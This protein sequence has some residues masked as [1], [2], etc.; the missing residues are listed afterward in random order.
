MVWLPQLYFFKPM[1]A[2]AG[3]VITFF[4][5]YILSW[6]SGLATTRI[7]LIGVALNYTITAIS[8]VIASM[9]SSISSQASGQLTFMTWSDVS[10]LAIYLIPILVISLFL[11]KACDMMGLEDKTLISLG[12]NVN[13]Y[14]F[15][16]SLIAVLLCSIS[17]S[18][19]GVISFVGLIVPHIA[20]LCIGHEHKYLLPFTLVLGSILVL[21][22]DTLGRVIIA[23]YELS[24]GIMMAVIGGPLFILLLKRG[25]QHD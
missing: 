18:V 25:I 17:V 14:R 4:I 12:V 22:A 15:F 5:I 21:L 13:H 24:S 2:F 7:L 16:I 19:V 9:S 20:R 8:D 10:P 6:K 11:Y 23:P 3:G 1:F